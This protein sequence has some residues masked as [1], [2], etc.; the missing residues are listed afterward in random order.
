MAWT[1]AFCK[2][3]CRYFIIII[4]FLVPKLARKHLQRQEK[5]NNKNSNSKY[6]KQ[7]N[8]SETN[9]SRCTKNKNSTATRKNKY[10]AVTDDFVL[11]FG[12]YGHVYI[13]H[14]I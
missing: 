12:I 6:D 11:F 10:T 5:N 8:D 2:H 3:V 14:I 7:R 4:S 1:F 9:T 13:T